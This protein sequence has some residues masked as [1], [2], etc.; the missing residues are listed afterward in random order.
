[1][2]EIIAGKMIRGQFD[3][4]IF[5]SGAKGMLQNIF[6]DFG[7]EACADF[8]DNLQN[9]VTEYMKLTGYSVGISD[10]I[11]DQETNDN[12]A[13]AITGK[14]QEVKDLLDQIKLGVFENTT[15]RSNR[16]EF[17]SKVNDILNN[18]R[19]DAGKIGLKSLSEQ[20]RFVNMVKAGSK[21]G[22]GG[23]ARFE[24][25]IPIPQSKIEEQVDAMTEEEVR[26]MMSRM[27][28]D[29]SKKKE[30]KKP[31]KKSTKRKGKKKK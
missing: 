27:G 18:A 10:L 1:M 23:G 13:K 20:N 28:Y 2:V 8:I 15:G 26:E 5:K 3:K 9:I 6:N 25:D 4:G 14:K 22:A 17:E 24:E 16:D 19:K 29:V 11:A 31:A 12:I 21:G 7:F 30:D